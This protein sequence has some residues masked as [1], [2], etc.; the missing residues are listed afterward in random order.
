MRAGLFLDLD[1]TLCDSVDTLRQVYFD[2]LA[3][4]GVEGS[5]EEF[6]RFNGPPLAALVAELRLRHA[7]PG[8]ADALLRRYLAMVDAAYSTVT[9]SS[10]AAD[11]LRTA[12]DRRIPVAVVTSNVSRLARRWLGKVGLEGMIDVVVG[13]DDVAEGKPS[14]EPYLTA[15][16]RTGCDASA[17]LAVEDSATGAR[18]AVA[19]GIPTLL[20]AGASPGLAGVVVI[21]RLDRVG[22]ILIARLSAVE[23][24]HRP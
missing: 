22:E 20:L 5:V 1:G 12:R 14:P 21:D 7:L 3:G 23:D 9:P 13:G 24:P 19:A 2:F 17:S 11:L 16:D 10:G 15:L 6:E 18:S 4:F 8:G